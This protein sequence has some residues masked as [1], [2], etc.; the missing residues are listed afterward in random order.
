ME[1]SVRVRL[2]GGAVAIAAMIGLSVLTSTYVASRAY[3]RR[4]DKNLAR[5]RQISVKGSA[6][7]RITSDLA[8]WTVS[9]QGTGTDLPGAFD[10]L[11]AGTAAVRQFLMASGFGEDEIAMTAIETTTRYKRQRDGAETREVDAYDM[12]RSVTI[13][14]QDVDRVARASAEVTELLKEGVRVSTA[15]PQFYY[16]KLADLRIGIL[17]EAAEDARVRAEEIAG[18]SGSRI[19]DLRGIHSGPIQ[20][21]VPNSTDVSGYGSYDTST[22]EKDA[23]VSVTVSFALA[24]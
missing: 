17:G 11:E 5:D 7:Q 21:T 20:L 23:S 16:T 6:R 22:I 19:D 24:S 15:R 8:V 4:A 13:T 2:A 18:R 9:V 12:D 14:T 10:V 1:Y 3:E